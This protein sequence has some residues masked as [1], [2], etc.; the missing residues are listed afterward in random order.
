MAKKY[1]K[2][3]KKRN[4][5]DKNK[6]FY[7]NYFKVVLGVV[8]ILAICWVLGNTYFS[9]SGNLS[10]GARNAIE[11]LQNEAT[12]MFNNQGYVFGANANDNQF[13][14]SLGSKHSRFEVKCINTDDRS[15]I[16]N[17]TLKG[18]TT[19]IYG[20]EK[21]TVKISDNKGNI[22]EY[23]DVIIDINSDD[24]PNKI[25]TDR[26]PVRIYSKGKLA[27]KVIPVNCNK[28]AEEKYG[29]KISTLCGDSTINYLATS[30][31]FGYNVIQNANG[32][33][34]RLESNVPYLSAD[35]K[36]KNGAQYANKKYCSAEKIPWIYKCYNDGSC[37]FVLAK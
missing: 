37:N 34:T 10:R 35:C 36:S 11:I 16:R 3:K 26:I 5:Y 29:Y 25:G 12:N 18:T 31:P 27:G 28:D 7:K 13:C 17:F 21:P 6:E 23:R 2:I 24:A 8:L 4:Q 1:N 14:T 15:L 19:A 33:K 20:M 30:T 9:S 22:E 32:K